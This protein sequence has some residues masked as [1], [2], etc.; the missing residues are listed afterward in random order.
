MGSTYLYKLGHIS[1]LNRLQIIWSII[2]KG[3]SKFNFPYFGWDCLISCFH[4][5]VRL[6]HWTENLFVGRFHMIE[7]SSSTLYSYI[8]L[9]S[10]CSVWSSLFP[11]TF[12]ASLPLIFA[13]CRWRIKSYFS[14]PLSS[15]RLLG[16]AQSLHSISQYLHDLALW[17]LHSYLIFS[18]YRS[19]LS[20]KGIRDITFF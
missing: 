2:K 14:I 8:F 19:S 16:F 12:S 20:S 17:F 1:I 5:R 10:C 11:I 6:L 18:W 7:W 9:D 4:S 15:F 13:V 3:I